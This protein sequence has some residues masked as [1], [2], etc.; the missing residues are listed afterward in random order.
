MPSLSR[1]LTAH[2]DRIKEARDSS[3]QVIIDG[4]QALRE[5][6]LE[7]REGC[8]FECSAIHLGVLTMSMRQLKIDRRVI[9]GGTTI[10]ELVKGL[11]EMQSPQW[12]QCVNGHYRH[13]S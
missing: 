10:M 3:V 6:Y 9:M 4:L 8:N 13:H 12:S 11:K 2:L 7:G 1:L 5:D